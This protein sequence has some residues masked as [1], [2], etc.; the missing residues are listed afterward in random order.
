MYQHQLPDLSALFFSQSY[1][2]IIQL[3]C[4]FVNIYFNTFQMTLPF[5]SE[6]GSL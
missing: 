1:T 5:L 2:F 4:A 6:N 3:P